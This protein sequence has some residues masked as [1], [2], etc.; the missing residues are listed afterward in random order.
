MLLRIVVVEFLQRDGDGVV[1]RALLHLRRPEQ[2]RAESGAAAG[3]EIHAPAR[4]A[5]GD[6]RDLRV[7]LA[8]RLGDLAR[9]GVERG[10]QRFRRRPVAALGVRQIEAEL[11]DEGERG[12]ARLGGPAFPLGMDAEREIRLR[13]QRG[14]LRVADG[15]RAG[16]ERLR[17]QQRLDGAR[18]LAARAD[19]DQQRLRIERAVVVVGEVERL[20]GLAGDAEHLFEQRAGGDR[21]GERIAAA[22]EVEAPQRRAR[23]IGGGRLA[24]VALGDQ[25]GA[26]R[27]R[28]RPDLAAGE[29]DAAAAL[30][31]E[32]IVG[33]E[34]G[35]RLPLALVQ[36]AH[37]FSRALVERRAGR[38]Q[39]RRNGGGHGASR[40]S[41]LAVPGRRGA[42]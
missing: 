1:G 24:A 7:V 37:Q 13:H 35:R 9:H 5:L 23:E 31:V 21:G 28:L 29:V 6:C 2:R 15:E 27:L 40:T 33:G 8:E 20:H 12:G 3:E 17:H 26:D 4:L 41:G 38:E 10:L 18:R 34:V 30:R 22:G 36:L 25:R 16:A 11:H 42:A 19:G 39:R 32:R 14:F